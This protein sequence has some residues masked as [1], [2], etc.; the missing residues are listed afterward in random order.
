MIDNYEEFMELWEWSLDNVQ[1]AEM[2]ARTQGVQ[3]YMQQ[4]KFLFGRHLSKMI[5]NHTDNLSKSLQ[6][7]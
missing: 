3:S 5:F 2:K 6:D 4:L 1:K 7:E